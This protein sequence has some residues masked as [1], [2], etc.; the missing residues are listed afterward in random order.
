MSDTLLLAGVDEAGLGPI[1]GPLTLGFSVL[2]AP[3]ATR[4]LWQA[5]HPIVSDDPL[6]DAS[7]F[8]VADSKLVFKRTPRC[9]KRLE[10]TALGF[11]ALLEPGRDPRLSVASFLWERPAQLAV[12]AHEIARHPWYRDRA[13]QLPRHWDAGALELRVESLHRALR[14]ARLELVDAGVRVVPEGELNR[15]FD[16]TDNKSRTHWNCSQPIF[17]RVWE[18]PGGEPVELVVDRHGGR[19]H[20]GAQLARAFPDAA[21]ELVDEA[22]ECSRYHLRARD[23]SREMRVTFAEQAE[24]LSFAVALGSCL[25]KYARETAMETLNAWFGARQPGLAPTAGYTTDGRRWLADAERSI[26]R[27]RIDLD[28]LVRRR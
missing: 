2:R 9:A 15:S 8:V 18:L 10:A 25:A 12:D 1:L 26:E 6:R 3:R 14:R 24:R 22:P 17:R 28:R 20:Y 7:A 19:M 23:G 16:E 21:V 13:A 4:D 11:L 5:L 27:E